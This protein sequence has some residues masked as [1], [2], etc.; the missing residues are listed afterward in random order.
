MSRTTLPLLVLATSSLFIR[1]TAQEGAAPPSADLRIQVNLKNGASIVGIA[2][3]GCLSERA[4]RTGYETTDDRS[5]RRS[6]VRVWYYRNLD[7]FLFL[8]FR[9]IEE[10][11]ILNAL[12]PKESRILREAAARARKPSD[13]RAQGAESPGGEKMRA[14]QPAAGESSAEDAAVLKEFP[15]E[16]GWSAERY[17]EI[18]RRR[19]V[20]DVQPT[21]EE[22]RFVE[23]FSAWE[24]AVRKLAPPKPEPSD[25]DPQP[26]EK[27]DVSER[28]PGRRPP[29]RNRPG[30]GN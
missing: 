24:R 5:D 11:K 25:Q 16:Q 20:N 14:E 23:V 17:G 30:G 18:Q 9:T 1:A 12:N 21:G 26:P 22:A 4:G 8:S 7:G 3:G 27:K 19:I 28:E 13:R 10:I 6:G 2:P 29:A 15:P